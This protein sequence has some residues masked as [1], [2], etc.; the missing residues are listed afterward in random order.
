M[1][2]NYNNSNYFEYSW[3]SGW[4]WSH[5]IINTNQRWHQAFGLF[6]WKQKI[7]FSL[8][9]VATWGVVAPT[10]SAFHLY[11]ILI[12]HCDALFTAKAGAKALPCR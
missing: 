11:N 10:L 5:N 7:N 8:S 2:N 12:S 3:I 9:V 6:L 1:I 4:N